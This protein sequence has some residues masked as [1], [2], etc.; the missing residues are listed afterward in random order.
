[1]YTYRFDGLALDGTGVPPPP[2][3]GRRHGQVRHEQREGGGG[4]EV[5][6]DRA[7]ESQNT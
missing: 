4:E 2:L 7:V 6:Q 3:G 5:A 1:M